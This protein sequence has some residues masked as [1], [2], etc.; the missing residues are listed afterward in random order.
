MQKTWNRLRASLL[1][2]ISQ[3]ISPLLS[4]DVTTTR[5]KCNVQYVHIFSKY[6]R[7]LD[8]GNRIRLAIPLH[9]FWLY[10]VS[11]KDIPISP[12]RQISL[13]ISHYS[14]T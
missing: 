1:L 5:T 9:T 10:T 4:L 6:T 2:Y 14:G 7:I 13:I 11:Y 12:V 3:I 8:E